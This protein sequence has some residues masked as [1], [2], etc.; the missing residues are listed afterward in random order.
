[1]SSRNRPG[2][3]IAANQVLCECSAF[4][5][6][7]ILARLLGAE[8]MGWAILLA[9]IFRFL[10]MLGDFSWDRL[11]VQ[12]RDADLPALRGQVHGLQLLRGAALAGCLLLLQPLIV[13]LTPELGTE[14][15]LA[16]AGAFLIRGALH[17]DYRERQRDH[18]FGPALLV[19][20]GSA[21]IALMAVAPIAWLSRDHSALAWALLIQSLSQTL[22]SHAIAR[23][24]YAVSHDASVFRRCMVYGAPLALNG[25]IMFAALQGD[26]FIV[27]A[28]FEPA[29]L[30]AFAI[31]A[32]LALLPALMGARFILSYFL[33][34]FADLMRSGPAQAAYGR[35]LRLAGFA[36][37]ILAAVLGALGEPLIELLYG[38]E[39]APAAGIC[40]LLALAAGLRLLRAVPN[41]LLLASEHTTLLLRTNV[42]RILAL[43]AGLW[44]ASQGG[45]LL[46]I[47]ALGTL[48]E[49]AGLGIA[50][51]GA[52]SSLTVSISTPTRQRLHGAH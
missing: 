27:A 39:Y 33:P 23:R 6:N 1:M 34:R 32:Q 52:A 35:T 18:A 11:L 38:A 47:V 51:I 28:Y 31:A 48:C 2:A 25:L 21:L 30:A 13:R 46:S 37:F 3:A 36:G 9:L 50:L 49:A 15:L 12:A 43:P 8:E 24:S 26:R 20:G 42:P 5:R 40:W 4:L 19:E 41:T 14:A 16:L 45:S 10:E 22:L 44:L 29:E 17:S 7:L